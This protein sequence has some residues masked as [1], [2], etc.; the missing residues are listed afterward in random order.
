MNAGGSPTLALCDV[1]N[2]TLSTLSGPEMMARAGG[3]ARGAQMMKVEVRLAV[4]MFG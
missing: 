2:A 4:L 3:A 1:G